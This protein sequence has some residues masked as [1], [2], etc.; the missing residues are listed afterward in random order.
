MEGRP[1]RSRTLVLA[2]CVLA[3]AF[4]LAACGPV[5]LGAARPTTPSVAPTANG[6]TVV[7]GDFEFSP[8]SVTIKAGETVTWRN[9]DGV[10]HDATGDSWTTGSISSGDAYTKAFAVPGT[11]SY[12]CKVH[13]AMKPATIIVR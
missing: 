11:Y 9:E 2:A 3:G 6:V 12:R 4:A 1:M 8:S 7:I 5:R 10:P 13:P